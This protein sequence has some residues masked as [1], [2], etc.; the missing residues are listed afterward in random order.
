MNLT[1][2]LRFDPRDARLLQALVDQWKSEGINSEQIALFT[3]AADDARR[4]EPL[5]VL[6]EHPDEAHL[7]ADGFVLYGLTR[8]AI[9]A[10]PG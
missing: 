1:I 3:R 2:G 7:M 6:C 9:E 8:P 4:G 5:R 10:L